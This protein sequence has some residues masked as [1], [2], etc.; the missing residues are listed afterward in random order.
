VIASAVGGQRETVVNNVTGLLVP[1]ERPLALARAAQQ[2]LADPIRRAGY[3]IAGVDRARARY[4]WPRIATETLAVYQRVLV[5]RGRA[6]ALVGPGGE[7]PEDA[8]VHLEE[9]AAE[10]EG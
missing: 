1:P 8:A 9:H 3:G 5:A 7:L 2:L 4:A 6:P 10:D